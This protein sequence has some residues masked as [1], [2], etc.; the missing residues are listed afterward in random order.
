MKSNFSKVSL[1]TN[2]EL[3]TLRRNNSQSTQI[4]SDLRK[5]LTPLDI[6]NKELREH[7]AEMTQ[8]LQES[9]IRFDREVAERAVVDSRV[10]EF[11]SAL[12]T[13]KAQLSDAQVHCSP[14]VLLVYVL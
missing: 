7:L 1:A 4:L 2:S 10:K 8:A 14:A 11:Q 6:E 9:K 12:E 3:E 5:K 13:S